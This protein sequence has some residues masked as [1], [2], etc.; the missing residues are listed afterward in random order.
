MKTHFDREAFYKL[1]NAYRACPALDTNGV[2]ARYEDLVAHVEGAIECAVL[3][4]AMTRIQ[5]DT[6]VDFG[7]AWKES[8]KHE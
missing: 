3:M 2:R 1:A 6:G 5:K 8:P 7:P 4:D